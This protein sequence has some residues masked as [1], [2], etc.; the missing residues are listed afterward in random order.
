MKCLESYSFENYSVTV[1]RMQEYPLTSRPP[2]LKF[3]FLEKEKKKTTKISS[4]L[5][6]VESLFFWLR[7]HLTVPYI[8]IKKRTR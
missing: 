6:L 4:L 5:C 1:I 7:N 3:S 8:D 2:L